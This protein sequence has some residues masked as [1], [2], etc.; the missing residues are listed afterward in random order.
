MNDEIVLATDIDGIVSVVSSVMIVLFFGFLIR[1]MFKPRKRPSYTDV[2]KK[3]IKELMESD[4][5][6]E[7]LVRSIEKVEGKG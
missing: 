5:T 3:T 7:D 4:A 1:S 2:G 6:I